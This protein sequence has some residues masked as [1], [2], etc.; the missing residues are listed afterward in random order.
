[1]SDSCPGGVVEGPAW[2]RAKGRPKAALFLDRDG[3]INVDHGYVHSPEQTEW[4]PDIFSFCA[5]ARDAGYLLVVVTNQA[6]I[7]RGYY[8]DAQFR[9]YSE[10]M[11]ENFHQ[12]G[13]PLTAI[14]Y[15]PCHPHALEGVYRRKCDCR[16]PAP[17]M[18]LRAAADMGIDLE[19]SMLVGD[20][21]SDI[22]AAEAAGL[23]LAVLF[24]HAGVALKSMKGLFDTMAA[25]DH[26]GTGA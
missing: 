2:R 4:V 5:A 11:H 6:G 19:S 16:K 9:A 15:C 24:R 25:A 18:L 8:D 14:Y 10:W 20:S 7:G 17:G 21:V 13:V 1:M 3:V 12:R 26:A 22:Q 23:S